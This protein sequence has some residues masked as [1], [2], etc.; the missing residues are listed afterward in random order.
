VS[1][2]HGTD[3][4]VLTPEELTAQWLSRALGHQVAEVD[5]ERV[6]TG[7][8]GSC[9][10][11]TLD[12]GSQLLAKLPTADPGLRQMLAGAYRAE[13][14]FYT[15][16]A[17]TVDVTVPRVHYAAIHPESGEFTLLLEDLA[18]WQPGDQ[19]AGCTRDQAE[20]AVLNLARLHGPRWCDPTL[21]EV[22][23]LSL[24]RPEDADLMAEVYGPATEIFL[25]TLGERLSDAD[26]ALLRRCVEVSRA[27]VLSRSERFSL[28][29]GDYR[30]DNLLFPADPTDNVRAVAAVDW[31][32]ISLALPAR[33]LAYFVATSLPT[34]ERRQYESRLVAAYHGELTRY[35][36]DL[37]D[38]R[39]RVPQLDG[40][41]LENCW[42]DYCFGMLQ[43]PLVGL[44]GCA[45][46]RRSE[47][48]DAMFVTMVQ[49]ACAA[50]RDLAVLE[51]Y[52]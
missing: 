42:D 32:T 45:Y 47:R 24:N 50:I 38:G 33:D 40:Y 30:L 22:E 44:F 48:G 19:I 41:T 9:F 35:A 34:P 1:A 7:Q 36:T 21:T 11:L 12:G 6:G 49:R 52:F 31:Q 27:W 26:H 17:P 18:P 16:L 2:A 13:V 23:G 3:G 39:R 14:R 10:R 46:G 5:V 43:G 20:D 15:D 8:I 51:S 25:T 4:V 37:N 29:H 28:V